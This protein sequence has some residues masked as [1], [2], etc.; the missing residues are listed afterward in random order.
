MKDEEDGF[1]NV[2]KRLQEASDE[3]SKN[4]LIFGRLEG[5]LTA[6]KYISKWDENVK[7]LRQANPGIIFE[8]I[9]TANAKLASSLVGVN[10]NFSG[11]AII[12]YEV[13]GTTSANGILELS[14]FPEN[15]SANAV[16]SLLGACPIVH[17]ETFKHATQIPTVNDMQYGLTVAYEFPSN[18]IISAKAKYNLHKMY[19]KTVSSGSSGGFLS[20][21]SWTNVSETTDFCLN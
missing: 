14:A 6:F 9:Q 7:A 21:R 4:Y 16:L 19:T 15:F 13:P 17:P 8:K 12:A 11:G 3:I 2:R 1:T 20:S 18:F 10:A 5:G